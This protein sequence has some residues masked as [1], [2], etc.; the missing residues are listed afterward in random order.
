VSPPLAQVRPAYGAASLAEVLPGALAA[1]GVAGPEDMADPLCLRD[2]L[3]GV[4][5]LAVLLVDGLGW[6]QLP[7]AAPHAPTLA[8]LATG[9][10]GAALELTCGFP[11]TTP[12]SLAT[13]GTG[14][15]P[16]AHGVLGFTV[17]RPDT[18]DV[19]NH[20]EWRGEPDPAAW[21][22][23]PTR[24]E[25][26]AAAGLAVTVVSRPEFAGSG[27]TEAAYRGGRYVG[28]ADVA[29]T[30]QEM[31]AALATGPG[32][33]YGYLPDLDRAGHL[34]GVDSPAWRAAARDTDRLLSALLD[35]L[36]ADAALLVTADHG[37]LDIPADRRYDIAADPRLS[38][39]L[40]TVAGEP[41]M[42]HLHT[43]A[44]ATGDVL[45]AWRGVL[46]DDAWVA[47]REEVVAAGWFGPVAEAHLARIGDVV[48]ACRDR[49]A[50]L[51]GGTEPER[52]ARLVA[53]H[54]SF[55]AVEMAIPLLV[56]R[57]AGLV[58]GGG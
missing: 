21:Q 52:V 56:A 17:R 9:R 8:D 55:T 26:A 58:G 37:Q 4:R 7:V 51:S 15:P 29:A 40:A 16:G 57:G 53:F 49:F 12:T 20:V 30:A 45:A 22:P 11:S 2:L 14:A 18:G 48:V 3:P 46:G 41:R 23:V 54:G 38:A 35:G 24:L 28:A 5:R 10:L 33:V 27:L 47:G 32:L 34:S 42:R 36:P 13:L 6:H 1:L 39:G 50:V 44:G 43:V 31:L 25:A 19:L